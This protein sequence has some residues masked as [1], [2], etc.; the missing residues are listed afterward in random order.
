M[1]VATDASVPPP[2]R[3]VRG[4]RPRVLSERTATRR[5]RAS[6]SASAA[7]SRSASTSVRPWRILPH[8]VARSCAHTPRPRAA[9]RFR[10][11]A[12][13]VARAQEHPELLADDGELE[14]QAAL[15]PLGRAGELL[16][17][18]EERRGGVRRPRRAGRSPAV[19]GSERRAAHR[20]RACR[21]PT[22][23]AEAELGRVERRVDASEAAS[24]V[25]ADPEERGEPGARPP[26]PRGDHV[27]ERRDR[28]ASRSGCP[29]AD[30][31]RARRAGVARSAAGG[32]TSAARREQRWSPPT[33]RSTAEPASSLRHR[34]PAARRAGA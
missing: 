16:L 8:T 3:G 23:L 28:T 6:T 24:S 14:E 19:V 22:E 33:Q 25:L 27:A 26:A 2:R 9:S 4:R 15:P 1:R 32:R 5:A 29:L 20:H 31:T 13:G 34:T 11:A 17:D 18:Q 21:G 10:A 12:E 7:H 30:P